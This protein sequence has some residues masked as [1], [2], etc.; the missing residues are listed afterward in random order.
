[1]SV[2]T[3][4]NRRIGRQ[5]LFLAVAGIVAGSALAQELEAASIDV[6]RLLMGLFGGLALFLFGIE[7]MSQGLKAVAGDRMATLLGGMTRRNACRQ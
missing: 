3:I 7:Q 2:S 1:M 6:F 5:L 4:I